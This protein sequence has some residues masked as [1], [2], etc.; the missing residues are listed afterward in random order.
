MPGCSC[1]HSSHYHRYGSGLCRWKLRS[2]WTGLVVKHSQ[3]W[4][5]KAPED[6][7]RHTRRFHVTLTCEELKGSGGNEL[8]SLGLG[9]ELS[10]E[11]KEGKEGEYT[12]QH[13]GSLHRLEVI[14]GGSQRA[15]WWRK[16]CTCWTFT[17]IILMF[18]Q[19]DFTG[20]DS[21]QDPGKK[22]WEQ[23]LF[24]LIEREFRLWWFIS[25]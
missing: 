7:R 12:R 23:S 8:L 19:Q 10:H 18:C 16:S 21:Q 1:G 20:C 14:C 3:L 5:S 15:T 13:R 9:E 22:F 2:W 25:G 6:M 11:H 24:K 17:F 4:W